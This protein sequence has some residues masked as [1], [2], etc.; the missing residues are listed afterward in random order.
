MIT[1][2]LKFDFKKTIASNKEPA[3]VLENIK[4]IQSK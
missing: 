2:T 4:T 3:A 1:V